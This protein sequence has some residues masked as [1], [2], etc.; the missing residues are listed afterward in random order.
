MKCPKCGNKQMFLVAISATAKY[1]AEN[2]DLYNYDDVMIDD[3][4]LVTCC[5][6]DYIGNYDEFEVED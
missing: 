6:C 1:D 3:R 2:D 4:E 5:E